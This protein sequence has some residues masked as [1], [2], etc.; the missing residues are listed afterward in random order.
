MKKET[1]TRT[2]EQA[3]DRAKEMEMEIHNVDGKPNA[4]AI[5]G[6][7][8]F[9]DADDFMRKYPGRICWFVKPF[10]KKDMRIKSETPRYSNFTAEEAVNCM[11]KNY[12]LA[13]KYDV[14]EA[15]KKLIELANE[16]VGDLGKIKEFVAE[17]SELIRELK[18]CSSSRDYVITYEGRF[19]GNIPNAMMSF[20]SEEDYHAVGVLLE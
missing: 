15:R 14:Q 20:L 12:K 16:Y 2:K 19:F 18:A 3:I 10:G 11:P 9:Y 17:Q 8:S 4:R 13:K 7:T 5:T 6:W 1:K